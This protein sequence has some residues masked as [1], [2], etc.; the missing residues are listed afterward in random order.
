M[1]TLLIGDMAKPTKVVKLKVSSHALR[2]LI[3]RNDGKT[4]RVAIE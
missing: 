3:D 4:V 2:N 1:R